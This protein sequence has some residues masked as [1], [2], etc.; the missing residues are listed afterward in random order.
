M[1]KSLIILISAAFVFLSFTE[2]ENHLGYR[3]N[4]FQWIDIDECA[5]GTANCPDGAICYNYEGSFTCIFSDGG[6]V[7]DNC[8]GVSCKESRCVGDSGV[9]W[10]YSIARGATCVQ[11]GEVHWNY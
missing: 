4:G 3:W 6:A 11:C 1:K 7:T 9:N 10:G 2:D 8:M 5:E